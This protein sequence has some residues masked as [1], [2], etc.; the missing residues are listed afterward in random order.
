[1]ATE[2]APGRLGRAP[3]RAPAT[4]SAE[5]DPPGKLMFYLLLAHTAITMLTLGSRIPGIGFLRPTLLLVVVIWGWWFAVGI[6]TDK[7]SG[8]TDPWGRRLTILMVYSIATLPFTMYPGSV[9]RAGLPTLIRVASF[10][11]FAIF[12]C[13]TWKRLRLLVLVWVGCQVFRVMQP[14][15]MH[16]TT[17]Y[18]GD[19]AY[20][21]EGDFLNRLAGAPG[22]IVNP[23]GLGFIVASV[24]PFMH[25]LA[26]GQRRRLVKL[27]YFGVA[28]CMLYG[29]VLTGSRSAMLALMIDVLMIAWR[30]KHR[31]VLLTLAGVG[32]AIS[33]NFM[34]AD[35]IDRYESLFSNNTR[36]AATREGR[37]NGAIQ[38]FQFGLTRPVFGYGLGTSHE[39]NWNIRHDRFISHD[40]YAETL[41]ELGLVGLGIFLGYLASIV[42]CVGDCR[43]FL[44]R[45]PPDTE[46]REFMQSL[47]DALRVWVPMAL[48][49]FF[50][51]YGLREVDWYLMGGIA[52]ALYHLAKAAVSAKDEAQTAAPVSPAH[53]NSPFRRIGQ[54]PLRRP[55]SSTVPK[56]ST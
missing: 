43:S 5:D 34:S 11:Y 54:R 40:M 16:V 31:A 42:R 24:L 15:F 20:M 29:L 12:L 56:R 44:A 9:L 22:D 28:L 37:V 19:H 27:A 21:G 8:V 13:T 4:V 2:V 52:G 1:V 45:A 48:I 23:N 25:Y 47:L 39:A 30:S 38:D 49:F 6:R 50:A 46:G 10:L 53:S 7:I 55:G 14:V 18:W 32:A 3:E 51:Q 41:I 17:G 36:N 33:L 35:L 26:M